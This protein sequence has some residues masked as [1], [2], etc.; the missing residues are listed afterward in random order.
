MN[1]EFSLLLNIVLLLVLIGGFIYFKTTM[2]NVN[3]EYEE[4]FLNCQ[5][6]Y[7]EIILLTKMILQSGMLNDLV[8]TGFTVVDTEIDVDNEELIVFVETDPEYAVDQFNG[9]SYLSYN[10]RDI[11]EI[12]D[13]AEREEDTE[14]YLEEMDADVDEMEEN[15]R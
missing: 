12:D 1:L 14:E 3:D 10:L 9:L 7:Q 2:D 13:G 8:P 6:A 5:G 11:V 15:P 4:T